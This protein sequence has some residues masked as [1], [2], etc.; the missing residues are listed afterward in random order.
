MQTTSV[1]L[2]DDLKQ[3]LSSIASQK[4]RTPHWIMVEA[5]SEY[6]NKEEKRAAFYQEGLESW[7]E[8]QRTGEHVTWKEAR[9]WMESWGTDNEQEPPQCHK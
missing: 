8:Y 2:S 9:N 4:R 1:K 3:R 7:Q 5:I 6:V